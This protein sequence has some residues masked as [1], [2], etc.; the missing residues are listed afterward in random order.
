LVGYVIRA[1]VDDGRHVV[2]PV[3]AGGVGEEPQGS[4]GEV[5]LQYG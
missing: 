2:P 5:S 4:A 3:A 1:A